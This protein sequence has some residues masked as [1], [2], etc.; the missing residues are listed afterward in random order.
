VNR[1]QELKT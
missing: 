1:K